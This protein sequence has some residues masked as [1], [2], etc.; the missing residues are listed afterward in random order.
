LSWG[1]AAVDD[2]K[3]GLNPSEG[4]TNPQRRARV[5]MKCLEL[6]PQRDS[7]KLADC[8]GAS[9]RTVPAKGDIHAG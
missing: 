9:A 8:L 3:T 2:A 1:C 7:R 4:A 6:A 5:M